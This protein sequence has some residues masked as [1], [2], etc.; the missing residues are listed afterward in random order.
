MVCDEH[1]TDDAFTMFDKDRNERQDPC[2]T[3]LVW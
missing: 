3:T 1:W 2:D